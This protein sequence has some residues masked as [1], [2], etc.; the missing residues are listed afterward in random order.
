M[1]LDKIT[2]GIIADDAIDA[3]KI[4]A[5]AVGTSE[6]A[7]GTVVAADVADNTITPIKLKDEGSNIIQSAIK[8]SIHKAWVMGG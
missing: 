2:R 8:R 3:T 4:E 6:I 7:D 5:N 1:A